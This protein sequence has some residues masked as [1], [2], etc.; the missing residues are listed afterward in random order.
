MIAVGVIAPWVSSLVNQ[1]PASCKH[2]CF[3]DAETMNFY[4]F[5]KQLK[6][7]TVFLQFCAQV[8]LKATPPANY[9]VRWF[10]E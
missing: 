2:Y 8:A 6:I 7:P 4:F 1:T 3:P 10:L 5:I 9:A